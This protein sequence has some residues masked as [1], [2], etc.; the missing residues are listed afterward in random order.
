MESSPNWLDLALLALLAFFALKALLRGF[1]REIMGLIGLAAGVVAAMAAY[2]P[3]GGFLRRVSALDAGWWEAAAFAILLLLVMGA[4]FW[5]GSGLARLMHAGPFNLL[6][7]FAGAGVGLVKGVLVAYLL[8]NLLL[9]V[10]PLAQLGNPDP[11][12]DNPLKQS[13]VAPRVIA[14]GR[15]LMDLL[16]ANLTRDLQERAGLITPPAKPPGPAPAERKR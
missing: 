9:L 5:L 8:I 15:Y 2:R 13:V 1:V 16:P 12:R 3:L 7:R 14:A 11:D 6:D 4:F 10:T